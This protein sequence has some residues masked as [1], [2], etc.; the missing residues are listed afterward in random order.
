[1]TVES[2]ICT[3]CARSLKEASASKKVSNTPLRLK[4]QKRFQRDPH[5]VRLARHRPDRADQSG[6]ERYFP[7]RWNVM[8]R[9]A[10]IATGGKLC[11]NGQVEPI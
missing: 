6:G 1:M 2:N 4:R 7:A 5:A 11:Q 9:G 8:D 3:R 10:F